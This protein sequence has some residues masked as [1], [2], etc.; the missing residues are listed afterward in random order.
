MKKTITLTLLLLMLLFAPC[1]SFSAEESSLIMGVFPR[2]NFTTT[3]KLFTPLA[4]NLSAQL[5]RPVILESA[6]DFKSFWQQV[7]NRRYD[8]VHFNQYHYVKARKLYGY[9]VIVMNEEYGSK[10][11]AGAIYVRK[12]SGINSVM[13]LKGKKIIFGGGP[14]AMVSYIIASSVLKQGGLANNDYITDFAINPPNAVKS[15]F[16]KQGDAAGA[17]DVVVILPVVT[18]AIDTSQLTILAKSKSLPHLPWAVKESL[19]TALKDRIREAFLSL[20]DPA[21]GQAVLDAA[22]LSGLQPASDRDF[23]PHRQIIQDIL[24]EVY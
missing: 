10:T 16:F 17:G 5:G 13:D 6:K 7:Q 4:E 3:L 15:L 18:Q 1:S 19:P 20:N 14:D 11:L 24:G 9:Q 21:K 23:D 22:K 8:I 12:D 2:R